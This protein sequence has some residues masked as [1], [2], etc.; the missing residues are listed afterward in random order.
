MKL[1]DSII[2]SM[3]IDLDDVSDDCASKLDERKRK[4]KTEVFLFSCLAK[5][6]NLVFP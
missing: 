2:E 4:I 1:L 3:Y 6:L 5:N